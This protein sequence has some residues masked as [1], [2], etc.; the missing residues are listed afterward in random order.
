[1]NF[2]LGG[3]FLAAFFLLKGLKD[4][5]SFEYRIGRGLVNGLPI[6]TSV[7]ITQG[8]VPLLFVQLIY[9]PMF[10]TSSVLMAAPW[11]SIIFILL[12]A[13][14]LVY[15][16]VYKCIPTAAE[17]A[18]DAKAE[19]KSKLGPILLF[20]TIGLMLTVGFFF[21]N[22]MTLMLRPDTWMQL[23]QHSANGLN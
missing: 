14:F 8:I 12:A 5:S 7:A 9:G 21:S 4:K 2:M 20:I 13:Y 10:Y 11:F 18:A 23:Y 16:V 15:V 3:A 22:N 6:Y 1:M 17:A 19:A